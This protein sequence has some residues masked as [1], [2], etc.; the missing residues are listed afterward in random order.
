MESKIGKSPSV[1]K[2]ARRK[3]GGQSRF[4][5][6]DIEDAQLRTKKRDDMSV[7]KKKL[8]K[9][10]EK[11]VSDEINYQFNDLHRRYDGKFDKKL[12]AYMKDEPSYQKDQRLYSQRSKKKIANLDDE[13]QR[14][15]DRIINEQVEA[16]MNLQGTREVKRLIQNKA[17][18]IKL[19]KQS[20]REEQF[21]KIDPDKLQRMVKKQIDL[22]KYL[23]RN[24]LDERIDKQLDK[25]LDDNWKPSPRKL[26]PIHRNWLDPSVMDYDNQNVLD[27][28]IQDQIESQ[29]KPIL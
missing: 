20:E 21:Q 27:N 11:I 14:E 6:K 26:D 13:T 2:P 19:V 10:A 3:F 29:I 16:Q 1:Y 22:T 8:I 12:D 5:K 25:Y 15:I 4:E 24:S 28:M 17:N 23:M 7:E 18:E 9:Q